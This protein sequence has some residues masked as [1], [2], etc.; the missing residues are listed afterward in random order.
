MAPLKTANLCIHHLLL[1]PSLLN[2]DQLSSLWDLSHA[3]S[4]AQ[5]RARI[6]GR[7]VERFTT[8]LPLRAKHQA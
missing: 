8:Q 3:P 7:F 2:E 5:P 6:W 1:K 4:L